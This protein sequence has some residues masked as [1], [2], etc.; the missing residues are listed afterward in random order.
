MI[1]ATIKLDD[2]LDEL[3]RL[4]LTEFTAARNALAGRLKK[5]GRSNEADFVKSL[6][7]P[8]ISAW[9]VNQLYWE[10]REAFDEL[11][12]SGE[13]FRE[14]RTSG[15]ARKAVNMRDALESRREALSHLSDLAATLL[16]DAGHNPSLDTIRRVTTTL[17]AMSA[18]ASTPDSPRAGRLTQD[19]DPP[20][21]ESLASSVSGDQA[22]GRSPTKTSQK[23]KG[24]AVGAVRKAEAAG[25][26]K[27]REQAR[28][29]RIAAAKTSLQ[30]SKSLLAEARARSESLEAAKKKVQA[31][32]KEAEKETREA[33]AYF[34]KAKA[35]SEAAARRVR[36]IASEGQV[37]A[38]A[39]EEAKRNV[40]KD[41]KEL[42]KLFRER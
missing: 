3:F 38:K 40:E 14:A 5:S 28:Q 19:V 39:L 12:E 23:S 31:E 13:R 21:F 20:G 27:K 9:A 26:A 11:I 41:T 8:P 37:A 35:A 4:P 33:E 15:L 1:S 7:K 18:Y 17:E 16:Q 25:V 2:E 30:E 6:T 22:P 34:K 36:S 42:E 29:A 24:T 10:H 32:A